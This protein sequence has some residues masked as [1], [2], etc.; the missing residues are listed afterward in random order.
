MHTTCANYTASQYRLLP[1]G[2][3][4]L[5]P[6][7]STAGKGGMGLTAVWKECDKLTHMHWNYADLWLEKGGFQK[8]NEEA[9]KSFPEYCV[10]DFIGS[11]LQQL[12]KVGVYVYIVLQRYTILLF[13]FRKM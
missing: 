10:P 7:R 13:P 12:D 4:G 8:L 5:T 9:Q 1:S 6:G 2:A 3:S 11:P